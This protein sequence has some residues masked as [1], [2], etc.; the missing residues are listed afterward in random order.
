MAEDV[1]RL[2]YSTEIRK[3]RKGLV[4][5]RSCGFEGEPEGLLEQQ[6]VR[7]PV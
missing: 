5:E 3:F 2:K 1:T 4:G 7:M 6:E